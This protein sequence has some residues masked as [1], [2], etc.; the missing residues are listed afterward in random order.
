VQAALRPTGG[1]VSF[2]LERLA[3]MRGR[4]TPMWNALAACAVDDGAQAAV[5]AR[6]DDGTRPGADY[7]FTTNDDTEL[8]SPHWA[9]RMVAA[10]RG[11]GDFGVVGAW[12]LVARSPPN[13]S[14]AQARCR[15][16]CCAAGTLRATR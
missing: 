9:V 2:R 6:P 10:L 4:T 16:I 13:T 3:G 1:A 8:H 12:R 14:A 5:Y 7:L 11:R 15:W